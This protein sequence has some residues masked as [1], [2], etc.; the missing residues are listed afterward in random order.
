MQRPTFITVLLLGFVAGL[1]AQTK[2]SVKSGNWS[3]ANTWTPA[4]VPVSTS[5]VF[6][7]NGHIVDMDVALSCNDITVGGGSAAELRY[8]GN[9][10]ISFT[11]NGNIT[12]NTNASFIIKP[13]STAFHSLNMRGSIVNNGVFDLRRN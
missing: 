5:D 10:A 2:T 9:A 13:S 1:L 8:A 12:V 11:V 6:I 4:G 3:D 7:S